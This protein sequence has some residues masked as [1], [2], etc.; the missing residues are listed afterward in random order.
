MVIMIVG[1]GLR[2]AAD[3]EWLVLAGAKLPAR[4]FKDLP[5]FPPKYC[6]L[7]VQSS[8]VESSRRSN[9]RHRVA[10]GAHGSGVG[11]VVCVC[12]V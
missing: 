4:Q 7:E 5:P 3:A 1:C 9:R 11:F 2:D 12:V 8:R 10:G 6:L